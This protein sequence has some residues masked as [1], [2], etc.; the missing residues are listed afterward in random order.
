MFRTILVP[1]DGSEPSDS[2]VAFALRLAREQGGSIIFAHVVE[3]AKIIGMTATSS[4]DPNYAIAAATDAGQAELEQA[5]AQAESAKIA[6]TTELVEDDTVT[7]LLNLAEQKQVDLVVMGSH[8][9][10]GISRAL[11]GSVTE[12]VLRHAPIPVLVVP[13]PKSKGAASG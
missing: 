13:A 3:V 1:V 8:G 4:I 10:S 11:L 9:R 7:G 6:A 2:A 5:K 12:G